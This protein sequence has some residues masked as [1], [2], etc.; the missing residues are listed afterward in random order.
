MK[1]NEYTCHSGGV[2][3]TDLYWEIE[4]QYSIPPQRLDHLKLIVDITSQV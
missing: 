3:G 2:I 4:I 1:K